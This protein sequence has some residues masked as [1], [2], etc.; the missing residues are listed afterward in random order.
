MEILT[1]PQYL[2]EIALGLKMT[3]IL[4][5]ASWLIAIGSGILLAIIR[6]SAPRSIDAAA[7][8]WIEY[9]RNVPVIV[10][11]FA[12]YF[13]VSTIFPLP[14]QDWFNANN[15]DVIFA[16]V[17]IGLYYGAYICEDIRSGYRSISRGQYE[18]ARSIGLNFRQSLHHVMMPQAVR[19]SLPALISRAI[20][21]LKS[22]SLAMVIGV[23][24]LTYQTKEI[25]NETFLTF[26][27][28]S[29][30]TIIYLVLSMAVILLG[31]VTEHYMEVRTA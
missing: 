24:E 9:Q 23:M 5:V 27:A 25:Q 13:G 21:L 11:I 31:K 3:V 4:A 22:T 30:A 26:Q 15:G 20:L 29:I 18:A 7:A 14:A 2:G 8:A 19:A 28:F 6:V 17:A 16:A 10:H 1:N 12:W